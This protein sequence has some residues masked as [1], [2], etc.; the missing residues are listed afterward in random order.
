MIF[1]F[2]LGTYI[3]A[4]KVQFIKKRK[5]KSLRKNITQFSSLLS[6]LIYGLQKKKKESIE[7]QDEKLMH[8]AAI[9]TLKSRRTK[10]Q[11]E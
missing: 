8:R 7:G 2:R 1:L 11:K 10:K 9:F 4:L 6:P 3:Y 5:R